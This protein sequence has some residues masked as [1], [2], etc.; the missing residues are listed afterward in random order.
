ME[1]FNC[2]AFKEHCLI[3]K[4]YFIYCNNRLQRSM[5]KESEIQK[6]YGSKL[7]N[8]QSSLDEQKEKEKLLNLKLEQ[9]KDYLNLLN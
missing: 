7:I 5:S 3:L 8:L 4:F 6:E 9:V 1:G 2:M